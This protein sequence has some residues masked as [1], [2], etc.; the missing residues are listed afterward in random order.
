MS[1]L[2]SRAVIVGQSGHVAC[3]VNNGAGG[4]GVAGVFCQQDHVPKADGAVLVGVESGQVFAFV[5][6]CK[7][8]GHEGLGVVR[9]VIT[10]VFG[11]VVK[12]LARKGKLSI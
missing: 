7:R 1:R 5:K 9:V 11:C 12:R 3:F 6:R 10:L 8:F 2:A 4:P